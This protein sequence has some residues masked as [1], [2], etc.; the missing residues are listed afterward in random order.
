MRPGIVGCPVLIAA[1]GKADVF[2]GYTPGEFHVDFPNRGC[3]AG[4]FAMEGAATF[5]FDGATEQVCAPSGNIQRMNSPTGDKA[6]RIIR[7]EPPRLFASVSR[8]EI[9]SQWL[10]RSRAQPEI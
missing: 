3:I 1:I 7:F 4:A 8:A 9:L 2:H 10:E 6:Q 5:D